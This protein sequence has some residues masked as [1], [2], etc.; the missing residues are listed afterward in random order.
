LTGDVTRTLPRQARA[1]RGAATGLLLT[2]GMVLLLS[3]CTAA[4]DAPGS[5]ASAGT[6]SYRRAIVPSVPFSVPSVVLTDTSGRHYDP[7]TSPTHP[8]TLL[9][10]GYTSCD[11]VCPAVLAD[12]TLALRRLP[13]ADRDRVTTVFVTTDPARDDPARIRAY[14]DR[15]DPSF[16]GLTGDPAAIGTLARAV[17]VRIAGREERGP[18][19]YVL[20]HSAQ[21]VGLDRTRHGVAVWQPDVAVDDLGHDLALLVARAA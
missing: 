20:G 6:T 12:L 5:R 18:G 13:A 19:D 1:R 7:T 3:G 15:F 2:A 10:F 11:D 14:L 21:V 8:V 9:F 17:G 4:A 16:V